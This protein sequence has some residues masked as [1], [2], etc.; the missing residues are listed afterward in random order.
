MEPD[1]PTSAVDQPVQRA[2]DRMSLG[3]TQVELKVAVA[4]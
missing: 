3:L 2:W 1:E 4:Y